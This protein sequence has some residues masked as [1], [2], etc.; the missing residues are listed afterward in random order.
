[1]ERLRRILGPSA[2]RKPIPIRQFD[3]GRKSC[4]RNVQSWLGNHEMAGWTKK[5][6]NFGK[7]LLRVRYLVQ[8]PE[9]EYKIGFT[10]EAYAVRSANLKVNSVRQIPTRCPTLCPFNHLGLNVKGGDVTGGSDQ[11]GECDTEVTKA[12]PD[13]DSGVAWRYEFTQDRFRPMNES[14]Q[15]IVKRIAKPPRACMRTKYQQLLQKSSGL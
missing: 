3:S 7:K 14:S 12:A 8:H 1:M 6:S 5:G 11:L 9:S 2:T 13:V 4:L 10:V 15:R